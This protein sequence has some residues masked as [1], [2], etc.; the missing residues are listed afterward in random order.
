MTIFVYGD[1][2]PPPF[3]TMDFMRFKDCCFIEVRKSHFGKKLCAIRIYHQNPE[4][5]EKV[6]D[7]NGKWSM[8]TNFATIKS[9][10]KSKFIDCPNAKD[11]KWFSDGFGYDYAWFDGY[12]KVIGKL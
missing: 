7:H 11:I 10:L 9:F 5:G 12:G 3:S 8:D 4:T 2:Q 1:K 6:Y